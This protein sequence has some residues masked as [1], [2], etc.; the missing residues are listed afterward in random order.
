[1]A[2]LLIVIHH[3]AL[4]RALAPGLKRAGHVV[5]VTRGAEA[6]ARAA[7]RERPDLILLEVGLRGFS[8]L[9]FHECLH[10]AQRTRNTPVMYLTDTDSP[11][12]RQAAQQLGAKA[13]LTK[14]ISAD[15]VLQVI[16]RLLPGPT[17]N[18]GD[19]ADLASTAS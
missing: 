3:R 18:P 6:G 1:M 4:A 10:Y 12:V 15:N 8:G 13:V 19:A 5:L 11:T 2:K 17:S 14:P 7:L 16:G 9:D